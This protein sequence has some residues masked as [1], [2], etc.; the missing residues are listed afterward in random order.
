M[1]S[2]AT[3]LARS[4]VSPE[5]CFGGSGS[6]SIMV[7]FAHLNPQGSRFGDGSYGVF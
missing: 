7:A 2:C 6:D 4:L 5:E 1:T 3:N